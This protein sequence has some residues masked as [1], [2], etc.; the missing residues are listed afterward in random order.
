MKTQAIKHYAQWV[1]LDD[2]CAIYMGR[3]KETQSK[4]YAYLTENLTLTEAQQNVHELAKV[5]GKELEMEH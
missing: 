4:L 5:L 1:A 3:I 2:V